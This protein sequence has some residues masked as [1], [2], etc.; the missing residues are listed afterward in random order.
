MTDFKAATDRGFTLVELMI[1]VAIV[2]VL[3]AIATYSIQRYVQS[4]KASEAGAVINSIRSA[5]EA[6]LQDTFVYLD[7]SQGN[8]ANLHPSTTPGA[9]KRSWAG[10]GDSAET[11]RRFRELGVTTDGPVY[12]SYGVV[13]GRAGDSLPA[14]PTQKKDFNFPTT[15]TEPFYVVIAKGDLDGDGTFSYL[16]SHSFTSEVYVEHEGE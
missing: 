12:F 10:N 7:V 3:G 2:G 13:A 5:E 11:S 1:V 4:A 16:M 15:A 9:F 14:L 8:F 6:Y